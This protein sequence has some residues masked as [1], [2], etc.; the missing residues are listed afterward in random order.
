MDERVPL[1][2]RLRFLGIYANN[3]DEFYRVRVA[4]HTALA[5]LGK[6]TKAKYDLE[7]EHMIELIN[8]TV[9]KHQRL[10][11]RT[12][13]KKLVPALKDK[14]IEFAKEDHAFTDSQLNYIRTYFSDVI[15]PF[16][17]NGMVELT[18]TEP[19][20]L[21]NQLYLCA[22][23]SNGTD[24]HLV[25]VR[26]PSNDTDRFILVP[27]K[28][29]E[30]VIFLDDVIRLCG[31]ELFPGR[32]VLSYWSIKMT[33][34]AELYLEDEFEGDIVERIRKSLGKRS[35]GAPT[36]M[37]F[38]E[39]MPDHL[40]ERLSKSIGI[41][42]SF[43]VSGGRYHNLSDLQDLPFGDRPE[44]RYPDRPPLRVPKLKPG[45]YFRKLKKRDVLLNFPYESYDH[46]LEFLDEAATDPEVVHIF[47]TLY[48]VAYGSKVSEGLIKALRNG[49][50]VTVFDEVK[51]RFDEESNIY[52]GKKLQ[53]AG[54]QVVFSFDRIKVHSKV[55]LVELRSGERFAVVSTG[56][57]NEKTARFYADHSLMTSN[58]KITKDLV[59]LKDFLADQEKFP[60]FKEILVAPYGLR[61]S[62]ERRIAKEIRNSLRGKKARIW[63]K[64]N[65]LEDVDM[66]ER[67]YD[68]SIAGV[69]IR[70]IIR[71]IC[72]LIPGVKNQSENIK[73]ISIVDRYLEH[74]RMYIFENGGDTRVY[75][76]SADW[77]RRNLSA[78]VEVAVP[79]LDRKIKQELVDQFILQ[80]NDGV[81]ARIINQAQS[82]PYRKLKNAPTKGSQE[83]LAQRLKDRASG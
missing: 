73:V 78:R 27:D 71:G 7:P 45:E 40:V 72:C 80:W 76:S 33:R 49:K 70:L 21:D 66:I 22:E 6:K 25:L 39:N 14:G 46:I 42:K 35:I 17:K 50:K 58:T 11:G 83:R 74:S 16:L 23:L 57:F 34:D 44:L 55:L 4:S 31:H 79:V 26:V 10:F 52:W 75:L 47:I 59:R 68:A 41:G 12:F 67:L 77:M 9:D 54:A 62:L 32:E 65:S 20:L 18:D 51:A 3:L 24:S 8:E 60:N 43:L 81:K 2:E 30:I 1:F 82:N 5:R 56:N 38:D 61:V 37:L 53:Q 15:K 63:L 19:F 29:K 28:K 48:R 36:R 13:F 64:L 69:E